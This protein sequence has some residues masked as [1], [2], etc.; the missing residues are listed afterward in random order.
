[1][2]CFVM[3]ERLISLQVKNGVEDGLGSW[4][5]DDGGMKRILEP[6]LIVS[7]LIFL[8]FERLRPRLHQN[9]GNNEEILLWF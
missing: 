3:L 6:P 4:S 2:K 5:G 8:N 1:M 9:R 7:F